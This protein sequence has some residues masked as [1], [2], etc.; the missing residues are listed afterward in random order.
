MLKYR[1][2]MEV[3]YYEGSE[4]EPTEVFETTTKVTTELEQARRRIV[5]DIYRMLAATMVG[6][7]PSPYDFMEKHD[8]SDRVLTGLESLRRHW[9]GENSF[10]EAVSLRV[11][12]KKLMDGETAEAVQEARDDCASLGIEEIRS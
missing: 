7:E 2:R 5:A 10:D 9:N 12:L 3:W 4:A 1:L 8:N 11:D 6:E